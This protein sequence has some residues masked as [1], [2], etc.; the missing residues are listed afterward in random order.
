M[1]GR[2]SLTGVESAGKELVSGYDKE[3]IKV[4]EDPERAE[5]LMPEGRGVNPLTIVD[6][7]LELRGVETDDL[8]VGLDPVVSDADCGV[9]CV[10]VEEGEE[11]EGE[12]GVRVER[13]VVLLT[14]RPKIT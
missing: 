10:R 2:D 6:P 9:D 1:N 8:V 12:V 7:R 4:E 14:L 13:K 3:L 11:L 5:V